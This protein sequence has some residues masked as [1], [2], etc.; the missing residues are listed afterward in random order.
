[1]GDVCFYARRY[2]RAISYYRKCLEMD[3]TFGPGHTDLARALEHIGQPEEAV[4]EFL[5]AAG[6][7]R[8]QPRP[9]R[10]SRFSTCG[11]AGRARR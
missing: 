2:D 11:L 5:K 9:P 4:D 6:L 7:D 1:M 10:A 8:G 3:P